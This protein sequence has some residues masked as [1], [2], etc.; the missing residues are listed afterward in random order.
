VKNSRQLP[1]M[2]NG[3]QCLFLAD[4]IRTARLRELLI[5]P[6]ASIRL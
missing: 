3:K 2:V 6:D 1:R 5:Q 4:R